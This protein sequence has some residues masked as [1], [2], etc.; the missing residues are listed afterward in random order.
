MAR[1]YGAL[2]VV[3]VA[4]CSTQVEQGLSGTPDAAIAMADG[5]TPGDAML[6]GSVIMLGGDGGSGPTS[7]PYTL[8][9]PPGYDPHTPAP[10][11]V[12]LHGYGAWGSSQDFYLGLSGLADKDTFLLALPDGTVDPTGFH[13]WNATDACCNWYGSTVDDVGY[14]SWLIDDVKAHYNVDAHHVHLF[15]HSN[16]AFLAHRMACDVTTK[17]SSI[18]ALAG[19]QWLDWSKCAPSEA[20]SVLQIHGDADAVIHY[21][22]GTAFPGAAAYPSAPGSV[23]SWAHFNGCGGTLENLGNVDLDGILAG[24]ET[25]Q[26]GYAGCAT[27]GISVELWTIQ[28]GG[29]VPAFTGTAME[30][31][32]QWMLSHGK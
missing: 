17:I 24:A 29:H 10:L 32:Y 6:D 13:F 31:V 11:V 19:D 9:V 7:R 20:I 30:T 25:L 28:G 12:L 5:A 14:I 26:Q 21:G 3:L 8:H 16:G 2:A 15:G 1:R 22:G 18:V 4:G 27:E 23:A